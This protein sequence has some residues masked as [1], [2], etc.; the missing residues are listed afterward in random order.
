MWVRQAIELGLIEPTTEIPADW[1][2]L[3]RLLRYVAGRNRTGVTPSVASIE[4]A[5]GELQ[6]YR[7]QERRVASALSERRQ[8]LN[9]IQRLIDSSRSYGSAILIQRDRLEIAK[10]LGAQPDAENDPL[11]ALGRGGRD[12]LMALREALEG[13]EIELRSQEPLTDGFDRERQIGRAVQQECRD[14]SRMPSSA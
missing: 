9:E 6:R 4:T 7:E 3:L 11:V 13:A 2:V 8:R 5:L 12:K 10:W 14:R 1:E